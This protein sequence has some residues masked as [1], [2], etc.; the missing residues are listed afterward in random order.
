[1]LRYTTVFSP[2]EGGYVITVSAGLL[3]FCL[4]VCL[5]TGLQIIAELVC[6]RLGEES[7]QSHIVNCDS[8]LVK[9]DFSY[10]NSFFHLNFLT[11]P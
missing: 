6:T 2:L 5:S 9:S 4:F 10:E 8:L 7:G 3:L 11:F 1:M